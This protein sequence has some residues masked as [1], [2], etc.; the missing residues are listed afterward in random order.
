MTTLRP[1]LEIVREAG[2]IGVAFQKDIEFHDREYKADGSV[3]TEADRDIEDFLCDRIAELSPDSNCVTEERPRDFREGAALTFVIDPIDGTDNF[4]NGMHN[5]SISIGVLD[6]EL[7]PIGGIVY[8]PRLDLLIFADLGEQ[9]SLGEHSLSPPAPV[10]ELTRLS[11]VMLSSR[12]YK[13][14]DMQAYPGKARAFG[15]AALHLCMPAIYPGVV[16]AI[17]DDK[18]FAWDVAGAHAIL[19]SLECDISYFDGRPLDYN[20]MKDNNWRVEDFIVAG[21]PGASRLLMQCITP[22][23]T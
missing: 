4:S 6:S 11:G 20:R 16:G 3:V 10:T 19:S 1:L 22:R 18:A 5:W 13:Q 15:S 7:K 17:Q 14:L 9:A 2:R 12:I 21:K 8:A 23:S